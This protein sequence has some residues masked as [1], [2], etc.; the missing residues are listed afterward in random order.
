MTGTVRPIGGA[1]GIIGDMM[2]MLGGVAAWLGGTAAAVGLAWFGAGMVVRNTTA[3]PALPAISV[4][5][6]TSAAPPAPAPPAGPTSPAHPSPPASPT[7]SATPI[8]AP[9]TTSAAASRPPAPSRRPSPAPT[10][11]GQTRSYTLQGGRVTLLVTPDSAQLVTAVPDAGFAVQTWSGT[12]WL[13]VDF[14]S[15]VQ[16]SSLIDSW[17]GHSPSVTV[18][19]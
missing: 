1:W 14:S 10:S 4:T 6:P 16:V 18:T 3:S 5:A 9:T 11:S 7:S 8:P 15:G 13:R 17:N 12:D 19:N 2:R